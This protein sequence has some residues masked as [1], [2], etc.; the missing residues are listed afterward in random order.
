MVPNRA[1]LCSIRDRMPLTRPL[2]FWC[3]TR[4][5]G[6][7]YQDELPEAATGG[8]GAGFEVTRLRN[9]IPNRSGFEARV[10]STAN[11]LRK[12]HSPVAAMLTSPLS[13]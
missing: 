10:E 13:S 3:S 6:L 4:P 2:R 11:R 9:R 5:P 7:N 12:S 8:G 1:G